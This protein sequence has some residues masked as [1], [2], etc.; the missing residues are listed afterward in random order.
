MDPIS[1]FI[2]TFVFLIPIEAHIL[3]L[4]AVIHIAK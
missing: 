4:C 1:I 3:A 2:T